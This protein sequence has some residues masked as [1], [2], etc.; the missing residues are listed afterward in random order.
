MKTSGLLLLFA[1]RLLAVGLAVLMSPLA[2][3]TGEAP[4]L[5]AALSKQVRDLAIAATQH[6]G[7]GV[8]RV[9]IEVGR[10]NPRLRLAPCA[11]VEPYLPR[12]TRLW[13]K[14]RIGLRCTQGSALWNVY[15]PITVKIYGQALVATAPLAIGSVVTEADLVQAEVDLAEDASAAVANPTLAVGRTVARALDPGDSFREAH[16]KPRLWFAAGDTVKVVA[17]GSG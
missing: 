5:D 8:T 6:A 1:V 12:G 10:L 2:R 3:A 7:D 16:L 11:R 9:D 15:L 4:A 17:V 14:T 13:G